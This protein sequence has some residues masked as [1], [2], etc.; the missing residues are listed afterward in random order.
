MPY[1]V[2]VINL[3]KE[4]K[5]SKRFRNRNPQMERRKTC[6]Y[7]GQ[8]CRDPKIRFQQHK[9]GYKSNRFVKKYG[10]KLNPRLYNRYNPIQTRREAELIEQQ[11]AE[12]LRRKGHGV[13][14]N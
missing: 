10:V 12:K 11:L 3:D 4:V 8:T 7:V 2:Y 9:N 14:S 13:W 6:L 1:Y 5:K